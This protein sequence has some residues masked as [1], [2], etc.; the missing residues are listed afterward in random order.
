MGNDYTLDGDE[1]AK[2][3]RM[4]VLAGQRRVTTD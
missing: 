2:E 4:Y 3:E 1:E